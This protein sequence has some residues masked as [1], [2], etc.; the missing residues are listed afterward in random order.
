MIPRVVVDTNVLVSGLLSPY[1]APADVLRM[2]ISGN[3]ELCYDTRII[4]EYEDVLKRAKF[5]FEH[6]KVDDIINFFR[7]ECVL[8]SPDPRAL[9]LKDPG[10][11]PFIEVAASS[12]ASY[13]ITGNIAHFPKHYTKTFRVITPARFLSLYR[14]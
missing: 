14:R 13:L 10:D 12:G 6:K 9:K 5:S 11:A 2:V 8:I 3:I 7:A 4:C 1:G